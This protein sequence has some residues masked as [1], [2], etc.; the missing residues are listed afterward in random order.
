MPTPRNTSIRSVTVTQFIYSLT[1][2]NDKEFEPKVKPNPLTDENLSHY[3][4]LAMKVLF[5]PDSVT[6]VKSSIGIV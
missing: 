2:S 5:L 3:P 6:L 4:D 1:K